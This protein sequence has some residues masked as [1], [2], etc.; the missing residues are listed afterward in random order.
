MR[1][2]LVSL[3]VLLFATVSLMADGLLP[4]DTAKALEGAMKKL[5]YPLSAEKLTYEVRGYEEKGGVAHLS[6]DFEG[7]ERTLLYETDGSLKRN[8][9]RALKDVLLYNPDFKGSEP[10]LD[11]ISPRVRSSITMPETVSP[12]D[13]FKLENLSGSTIAV[14]DVDYRTG[15][16]VVLQPVY[17]KTETTGLHLS[18]S[19]PLEVSGLVKVGSS[20]FS[21]VSTAIS[22]NVPIRSLKALFRIDSEDLSFFTGVGTTLSLAALTNKHFTLFEDGRIKAVCY[23]GVESLDNFDLKG[24]FE[25]SYEHF[26]SSHLFWGFGYERL[27]TTEDRKSGIILKGGYAL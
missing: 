12:G 20:G 9:Y 24:G 11:Y 16:A 1:R 2:V 25:I 10:A 17:I 15:D 21:S 18:K 6:I 3:L 14:Y 23:V 26:V 13:R 19:L 27:S 22:Y 8:I 5:Y 4:S 7:T